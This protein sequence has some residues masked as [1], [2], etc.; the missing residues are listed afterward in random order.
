MDTDPK[1]FDLSLS[2][3]LTIMHKLIYLYTFVVRATT[4][5]N[6]QVYNDSMSE[7]WTAPV[8]ISLQDFIEEILGHGN[9][10]SESNDPEEDVSIDTSW[11]EGAMVDG[12]CSLPRMRQ[13][14]RAVEQGLFQPIQVSDDASGSTEISPL[15]QFTNKVKAQMTESLDIRDRKKNE[16]LGIIMMTTL[17]KTNASQTDKDQIWQVFSSLLLSKGNKTPYRKAKPA[18][19]EE[20]IHSAFQDEDEGK[21][22]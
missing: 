20:S 9:E 15:S 7:F 4:R 8:F 17:N 3:Q 1:V 22:N 19:N 12:K 18:D 6:H 14:L 21:I 2:M 10:S 5:R 16:A 13:V 11:L